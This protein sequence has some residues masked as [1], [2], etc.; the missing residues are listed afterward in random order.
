MPTTLSEFNITKD[1]VEY[2]AT[3][4]TKNGTFAFPSNIPLTKDL[5]LDIYYHCL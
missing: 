4:L 1:D 5:V 2:M 3:R